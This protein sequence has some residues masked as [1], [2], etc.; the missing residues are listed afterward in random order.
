[1]NRIY[2]KP[3]EDRDYEVLSDEERW[4][5]LRK[6]G[7]L[8]PKRRKLTKEE[9]DHRRQTED[10]LAGYMLVLFGFFALAAVIYAVISSFQS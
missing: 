8:P 2:P 10:A 4:E 1:M 6:T 5:R 7:T 9:L 3:D